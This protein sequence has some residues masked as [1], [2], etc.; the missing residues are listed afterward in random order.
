[1]SEP[2]GAEFSGVISSVT[3]FGLFVSLD[4]NGADGLIP[5]SSLPD[6]HYVHDEEQH[7]LVGRKN[8][9][10]YRLGAP[11]QIK[12]KEAD[13]LTGSSLFELANNDSA[14]IPGIKF[15]KAKFSSGRASKGKDGY[16]KKKFD[17]KKPYK[18]KKKGGKKS[19]K[20]KKK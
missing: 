6:D 3:R 18:G 10:I 12:L 11:I 13:G 8:K 20:P 7:A 2:I 9:K 17:K 4:E 14:D 19:F 15:K 5:M 16:K 1:M